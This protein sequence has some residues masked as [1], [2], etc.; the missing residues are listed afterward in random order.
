MYFNMF[1]LNLQTQINI[2]KRINSILNIK[3]NI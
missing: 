2:I 1:Y 3:W